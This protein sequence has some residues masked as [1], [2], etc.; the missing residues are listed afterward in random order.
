MMAAGGDEV[1][2]ELAVEDAGDDGWWAVD[3]V[4]MASFATVLGDMNLSGGLDAGDYDAFALGMLDTEA[5]RN[6]Y[7]GTFPAENGSLDSVFD[8]DD[9]PWFVAVMKDIAPPPPAFAL[10]FL[11]VPEPA[12]VA[13]VV[14]VI[15]GLLTTGRRLR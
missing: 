6:A 7:W 13:T 15:A 8:F 11:S 2:I 9:I 4:E 1:Q 5:Y 12:G 14:G 3:N 10:A